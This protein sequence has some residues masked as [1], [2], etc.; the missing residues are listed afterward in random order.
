MKQSFRRRFAALATLL[1][2]APLAPAQAHKELGRMWTFEHPPLDFLEA[3]YGFRPSQDWLDF[4]R[5]A[6]VRYGEWCSASFVSPRGMILTNHHCAR[7]NV[8]AVTPEGQDWLTSGWFA[9]SLDEEVRIPELTVQQLVTMRDVT[10]AMNEGIAADA[11]GEALA[12][13]LAANETKVLDAAKA[14]EPDLKHELVSLYQ[15]GMYQVYSYKVYDDVRLVATPDLRIAKFGG[16][17][18]NF[19]YPRFS[20]DYTFVRAWEDGKPADTSA[21]YF[22]VKTRGPQDGETVFVTGNPGSTG[23]LNTIAQ[24]E[25]IRDIQYPSSLGNIKAQLQQLR[26]AEKAGAEG[27]LRGEILNL[28][29][30]EKA[31]TGYLDGLR[32]E[33]V[34]DVKRNAE[35]RL[36]ETLAGEERL[37]P[38]LAAFDRLDTINARKS[39]LVMQLR[40]SREQRRERSAELQ[41]LLQEEELIA[42]RIGEAFFAVYGTS[43]P[44]DATFTLRLSDGV[45]KGF[46]M[47]GTIAPYFTS[48]F[49]LYA[50]NIE[51]ANQDPFD[52]DPRWID[53]RGSLDLTT[54][55][56]HVSTC[57]IIG[58][59]SG[60]P[61][62]NTDL[63]LVGLVFDGNIESLANRFVF[64]DDVP[65]TVCVHPA[66]IVESLRK[67]YDA[68]A[69][70]DEFEGKGAGY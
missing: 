30:S 33:K 36:R 14:A 34:M 39:E 26:A 24:M 22:K 13:A 68:P 19:T 4:A 10:D 16:D 32:N 41:A 15:G 52:L 67:I 17:P 63:E 7:D 42:K 31:I 69:I 27:D 40:S 61:M 47:N 48:L 70:A 5:L 59:N 53:R 43:I 3:E 54:P 46:P 20:L 9:K 28:E 45:V 64:T 50:R 44:P 38:F 18:D 49:G 8:A 23:R 11:E 62:I 29:N 66:I 2:L 6:S 55:F 58:G 56:C 1:A 25:F 12:S 37:A 51:F 57:D 60:S 35:A 21:H 65:R